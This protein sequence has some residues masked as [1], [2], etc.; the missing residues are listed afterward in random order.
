MTDRV[1]QVETEGRTEEMIVLTEEMTGEAEE[2][3]GLQV[4]AAE[5]LV[6]RVPV[7][8]GTK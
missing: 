5:V 3:E 4:V 1:E 7:A 6:D 8:E 2:T